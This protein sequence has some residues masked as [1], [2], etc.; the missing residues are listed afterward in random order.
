LRKGAAY[1]HGYSIRTVSTIAG[2]AGGG[3]EPGW[4]PAQVVLYGN[5]RLSPE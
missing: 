1:I 4:N 3:V 5:I 2:S